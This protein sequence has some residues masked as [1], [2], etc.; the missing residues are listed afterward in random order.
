MAFKLLRFLLFPF[1]LLYGLVVLVRNVFFDW[2]IFRAT[3]FDIPVLV[4]G[5]ITLGG[6]GKSPMTEYLIRLLKSD[7]KVAVLSRGYGRKTKGFRWV[8]LQSKAIEVGDEPLQFKH[9]FP[10]ISVA[11][12][13]DR[14]TG[15]SQLANANEVVLLDD[16]FQH[17]W[18]K[19]SLSILLL[20]YSSIRTP[21]FLLPSGTL[22]EPKCATSRADVLVVSKSP[23]NISER[24]KKELLK[25]IKPKAHQPVF[26]SYLQYGQ[27][28]ELNGKK[29]RA[30][31]DLSPETVVF[32]LTG[33]ANAK[34][35]L[36]EIEQHGLFV[37]H[38][39]YPDHYA[40]KQADIARLA[41]DFKQIHA[42]DKVIVTT[43]KDA[44]RLKNVNFD[45]LI[46]ELPI[47]V[48]PVETAFFEE[49][50]QKFKQ[51]IQ[52]HVREY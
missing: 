5:N 17:R 3:S 31:A 40:F 15:L 2:G 36:S 52:T 10:D 19:P 33:I 12:C 50:E 35:L 8:E 4:I 41:A 32:L 43:E 22:R 13:E 14:V 47:Y 38:H 48:L 6:S 34:P 28:T 20:E 51:L 49:E 23:K 24:D 29:T 37:K 42:A 45:S 7:K 9:H 26:F 39:E 1:S 18:L 11:V 25:I 21:N 44:Q 27:L 16:A 46:A 30:L